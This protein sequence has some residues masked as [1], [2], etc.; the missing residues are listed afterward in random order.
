MNN[1]VTILKFVA[2]AAVVAFLAFI[3][4][5]HKHDTATIAGQKQLLAQADTQKNLDAA[6]IAQLRADL[7]AQ[8]GVIA[9]LGGAADAKMKA[10]AAAQVE[11]AKA[12]AQLQTEVDNLRKKNTAVAVKGKTCADAINEWRARQ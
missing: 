5:Q 9:Q 6:T 12:N 1:I 8:S 3:F 7:D 4:V 10:A 2:A 11:A